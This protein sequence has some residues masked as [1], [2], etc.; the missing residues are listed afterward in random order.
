MW[1]PLQVLR[2][3]G[4]PLA[5]RAAGPTPT[6]AEMARAI[7]QVRISEDAVAPFELEAVG[8]FVLAWAQEWPSSFAG[9]FREG[10]AD[11]R[12]WAGR[13]TP[14][15]NRYLKLRRIAAS[16]LAGVL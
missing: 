10:A 6:P 3:A 13:R 12:A 2:R 7:E 11:T 9:A 15:A 16:R 14:D 8:A 4:L 5:L 1:D